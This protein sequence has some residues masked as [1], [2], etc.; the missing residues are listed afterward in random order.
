M[1]QRQTCQ[2]TL[3]QALSAHPTRSFDTGSPD[4]EEILFRSVEVCLS[5]L[6]AHHLAR[7]PQEGGGQ[8]V[9]LI[10]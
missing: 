4:P 7:S 1:Q 6:V 5:S 8:G 9:Q 2:A 10:L 3:A